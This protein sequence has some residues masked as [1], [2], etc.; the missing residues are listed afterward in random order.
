MLAKWSED[1]VWYRV[2]I[3]HEDKATCSVRFIDYGNEDDVSK[4]HILKCVD[5]IPAGEDL[6]QSV[7]EMF[8]KDHDEAEGAIEETES[9]SHSAP[10][11]MKKSDYEVI[12]IPSVNSN[13]T[14]EVA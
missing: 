14:D 13:L 2:E 6:D 8:A 4:E 12:I 1:S 9:E 7:S 11:K 3:L 10:E 5:D